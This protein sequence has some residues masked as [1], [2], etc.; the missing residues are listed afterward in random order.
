[1]KS[2]VPHL[3][4][5]TTSSNQ[6][7]SEEAREHEKTTHSNEFYQAKAGE[8]TPTSQ[9]EENKSLSSWT[10]ENGEVDLEY[11]ESYATTSRRNGSSQKKGMINFQGNYC[12]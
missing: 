1:M 10:G 5:Y 4:N 6:G 8:V 11:P 2:L 12:F 3:S 7:P 9:F